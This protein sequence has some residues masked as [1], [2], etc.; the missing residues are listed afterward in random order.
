VTAAARGLWYVRALPPES[1]LNPTLRSLRLLLLVLAVLMAPALSAVHAL[2]HLPPV[3]QGKA[4][5][6]GHAVEKVCDTCLALAQL[7]AALPGSF[8][9]ACLGLDAP[10]G[11]AAADCSA[12]RR[13]L[14]AFVARGPPSSPI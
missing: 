4:L 8:H 9:A 14:F 2:S 10:Q 13:R 11:G 6:D 5:P 1:T 12:T 7:D 3:A